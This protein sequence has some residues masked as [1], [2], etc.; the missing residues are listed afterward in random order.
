MKSI[1]TLTFAWA[2][3]VLCSCGTLQHNDA[4]K[5]MSVGVSAGG[6]VY[7][8]EQGKGDAIILLHGHSLDMRMWQEQV[9]ALARHFRVITPDFR[10]YGLS[11]EMKEE[12]HTTHCDDIIALM[13]ALHIERAH[14]VGL[15]MGA[16]VAG[17]MLAMYP[18]RL[19]SCTL[20]SGGI[21]NSP[22]PT[23][24]EDSVE[25]AKREGEIAK[26]K[27]GGIEKMKHDW[28]EQLIS[29]GGTKRE[30]M[31]PML[32]RMIQEWTAWQPLHHE[33]RLFYG[34]EAWQ[35]LQKKK[36]V[37]VPLLVM[38][39]ETEGKSKR[40]RELEY[41]V[42]GRQVNLPDCGHM[43]NMERP[44]EFNKALLDFLLK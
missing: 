5:G 15:S 13:N 17:D 35:Q 21:R 39:G 19:L 7:Y 10:G 26:V 6:Y 30:R 18:E 37:S 36:P 25:W 2:M 41:V 43:M 22:P 1:K 29:G 20:C 14:V 38:R 24:P 32:T 4:T 16:F 28:T 42:N 34:R 11:S 33:P 12:L 9:P 27:A 23:E 31:R 8:K 3:A 44:K 40:A